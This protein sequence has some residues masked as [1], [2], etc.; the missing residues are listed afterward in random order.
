VTIRGRARKID[1]EQEFIRKTH[2][3]VDKYR[4]TLD[5]QG[6]DSRG[7]PLFNQEIRCVVETTIRRVVFW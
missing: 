4:L 6:R 2:D 3:H 7:I 1:D 5:S